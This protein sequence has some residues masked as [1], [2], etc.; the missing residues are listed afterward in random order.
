MITV[1]KSYCPQN[2]PCPTVRL[3]PVGAIT[4]RGNGAPE[5]DQTKCTDCGRCASSC[6]AFRSTPG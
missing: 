1:I 6:R 5:V 4:Q 2:H 3:C